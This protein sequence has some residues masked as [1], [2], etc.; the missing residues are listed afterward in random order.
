VDNRSAADA[1]LNRAELVVDVGTA[2]DLEPDFEARYLE[3]SA[4]VR[5]LEQAGKEAELR[6]IASAIGLAP[7]PGLS[8][9]VLSALIRTEAAKATTEG[10]A[11][12][13]EIIMQR[14]EGALLP[15]RSQQP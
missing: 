15:Y 12:A 6:G 7:Q 14:V 2:R 13:R 11:A 4:L 1:A 3:A 8:A 10:D 9:K 5:R